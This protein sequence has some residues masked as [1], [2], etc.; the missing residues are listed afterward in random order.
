MWQPPLRSMASVQM[1]LCEGSAVLRLAEVTSG[2]FLRGGTLRCHLRAW[3]S[4]GCSSRGVKGLGQ[5]EGWA[6]ITCVGGGR[7]EVG[8]AVQKSWEDGNWSPSIPDICETS[9]WGG[10]WAFTSKA[11]SSC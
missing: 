5:S 6:L 11:A 3:L 9:L 7:G 1:L 2:R 10:P 8:G 4:R